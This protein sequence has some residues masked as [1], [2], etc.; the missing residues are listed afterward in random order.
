MSETRRRVI[1]LPMEG[2]GFSAFLS[3]AAG[4]ANWPS[5]SLVED[6]TLLQRLMEDIAAPDAAMQGAALMLHAIRFTA[7]P[8]MALR[9]LDRYLRSCDPGA[10]KELQRLQDNAEHRHFLCSLFAFSDYLSE[11]VISHREFLPW[12]MTKGKLNREK[13]LEQYRSDARQWVANV[14]GRARRRAALTRFKKRELLRIGI[15]D[16]LELGATEPLCRELSNLAQAILE[17]SYNDVRG[18]L[19]ARFGEPVSEIDGAPS[20]YCIYAM[21]KFGAGE[22]NFSSDVDLIFLYDDEGLTSGSPEGVATS[23]GRQITNHEFFNRL[24]REIIQ[25]QS[26]HNEEGFLFRVD[27][28]LRPE[29]AD[30]PLARG[31]SAF[32]A[33]LGSGAALWEK[34]AYLKA[35]FVVGDV[36]L[37][38]SLDVY[39]QQ[40]VFMDNEPSE[41]FPE[42]AR[43]KR[44]IDH[45]ALTHETRALDIKRGTG[46][47]REI[48]FIVAGLQLLHG[49][50]MP[51]FR[52]RQTLDAM[53]LLAQKGLMERAVAVRLEEAYHLFRRI[54]HTLQMMHESQTHRMPD[55][56]VGRRAMALRCGFA[57]EDLFERILGDHRQFV[58]AEFEK[59]FHEGVGAEEML[60]VDYLLTDQNPPEDILDQLSSVGLDGMEGMNALR[61]L[62]VGTR[63]FAP[64]ARGRLEFMKLLPLLLLELP[65]VAFPRQAIRNF[66]LLLRAAKGFTWVYQLCLSHPPILKMLMRTLGF[67]SLLARQLVAHPEWLDEIFES[68]GL[69]ESRTERVL[70]GLRNRIEASAPAAA[71]AG[72]R[73]VKSLEGFLIATQEALAISSQQSAAWR[74]T[75]LAE[76][77]IELVARMGVQEVVTRNQL[78]SFPRRWVILGLG[79]LGDGQVHFGGDLDVAF[80]VECGDDDKALNLMDNA[81]QF[82]V[83]SMCAVAPEGQ[84]WKIDARLRPDGASSPLAAAES[85]FLSY[86]RNEAGLWEWQA[87]TKAR[88]VA[89]DIAFGEE[90]LG[91]LYKLRAELGEVPNLA[92]EI[93]SMRSR[94]EAGVKLPRSARHDL[95]TG[96]GGIV[97]AEFL[98]QYLTLRRPSEAARLFPLTT[99][100]AIE[101]FRGLGDLS[102]EDANFLRDHLLFLRT[103]QRLARLLFETSKDHFPAD[104]ERLQALRRGLRDQLGHDGMAGFDAI[105]DGLQRMRELFIRIVNNE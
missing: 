8:S 30:G 73:S 4:K 21:G 78:E 83:S 16:L 100:D 13:K 25:Y 44:R 10:R 55:D 76:R 92:S 50:T 46:G 51:E 99:L 60:L 49:Q 94:M 42:V 59:L 65:Y 84:L 61:E 37:G 43:L 82:F 38:E 12:A 33:Y 47:I 31:K 40:F 11:I 69:K 74:M 35:R 104:G 77:V 9:N 41:L 101:A 15:R 89:G 27:A 24:S 2:E 102:G 53:D 86:Y 67:G 93:R 96:P 14:E 20:E 17:V 34:I 64:S 7:D 1:I 81:A 32:A 28:R 6:M 88:P 56:E 26:D 66:D 105:D 48:E 22:L 5:G 70:A 3:R 19:V 52:I 98:V 103:V 57:D 58:R 97:D 95:K 85:R 63:E 62:A 68:D 23:A 18:D 45:D 87:L 71:L 72:L 80:V 79:G 36:K 75:L 91:D 39:I 54:E 90:L 29:G